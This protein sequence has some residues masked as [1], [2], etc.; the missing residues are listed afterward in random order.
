[1]FIFILAANWVGVLPGVGTIGWGHR[2]DHGF[3]I[4][5]PL[6]RGATADLTT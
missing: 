3:T 1:V 6:F 5:R 4:D 2:T